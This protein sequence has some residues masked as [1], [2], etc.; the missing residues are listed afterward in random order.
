MSEGFHFLGWN[1]RKYHGK[2]I[3]KSSK[4]LQKSLIQKM[5]EII[6]QGRIGYQERLIANINPI[7][8]GW[9]IYHKHATSSDVFRKLDLIRWGMLDA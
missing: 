2:Y 7:I 8:S 9:V 4:G 5:R 6:N 1:F 3:S